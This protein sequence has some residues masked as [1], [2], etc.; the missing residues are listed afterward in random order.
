[1]STDS[2]NT[3]RTGRTAM[4]R[5][6]PRERE[7]KP[8]VKAE[9]ERLCERYPKRDAALLPAL[10][11]LEREF[12]CV[13]EPGMRHVAALLGVSPAKVFGVFTFYTHYRRSTDGKYVLQVCSTLPCALRGSEAIFDHLS[14]QLGIGKD[15]TTADGLF[16]LKK[17]ECLANCDQ[18]PC[19]Q[20]NED[21]ADRVS[22]EDCD[23][24]IADMRSAKG[25]YHPPPQQYHL[26]P[27]P[28]APVLATHVLEPGSNTIE[29]YMKRGGYDVARKLFTSARNPDEVIELVLQ[30]GLR[31][32]GGAGFPTGQKWK[33]LAK[34]DKPRYLVV[35]ADESEPGTFKDKILIDRDPHLMLEGI[36]IAAYAIKSK[37]SYIYIRGEF[38]P[39][40]RILQ[41]AIDEAYAQGFFGLNVFGTGMQVDVTV[42]RGAGAY[43]CGE[44][45]GLLSS[46]EGGRGHPKI[47]PPFPAVEG[48]WGCPTIVNNVETLAC[49]PGIL[50]KG[51]AWFKS[52]GTEKSAGTKLFSISGHVLRPGNYELPLGTPLKELIYDIAGGIPNG[53]KLKAV[54]PGGS[55]AP[56]LTAEEVLRDDPLIRLDFESLA[57]AG[58]MLGSGAIIVMDEDTCMVDALWNI[59][60][61]YAHE[62]CGQCTPCREGT[63]WI[64]KTAGR[65]E[66]GGG[67]IDEIDQFD[68]VTWGMVGRTICVLADAAAMPA[69]SIIRK[70]RAEFEAHAQGKCPHKHGEL[71][72]LVKG[73]SVHA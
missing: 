28:H 23:R 34:N 35:N 10:R 69:R 20:I 54:C 31:G 42:H 65:F 68:E 53:K 18:A 11:L 48:A 12:G 56:F 71:A 47:K 16:T 2:T 43:I 70:F 30:S 64:A 8:E 41:Q 15:E 24:M 33:F 52:R 37:A 73:A 49:L 19:L 3:T 5:P 39:G 67:R 14:K 7:F 1:M 29:H 61:F 32:R 45:T 26:P 27:N 38:G 25:A 9:L 36:L 60:R 17:V 6:P 40:A 62:S 4:S 55:S 46:L 59:L 21:F 57:A 58:T 66:R 50:E 44:E 63:G 22:P 72:P 13:D 51:P